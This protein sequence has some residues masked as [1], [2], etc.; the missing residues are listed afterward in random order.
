MT[1]NVSFFSTFP[2][3]MDSYDLMRSFVVRYNAANKQVNPTPPPPK[4]VFFFLKKSL[5]PTIE[6]LKYWKIVI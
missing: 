2:I 5:V 1:L 4:K 3:I 6:V